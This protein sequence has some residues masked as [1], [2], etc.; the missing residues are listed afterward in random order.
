MKNLH[1]LILC[2][3]LVLYA[4]KEEPNKRKNLV[5]YPETV[6]KPVIETYF[7]TKVIDNYRWLEDDRSPETEEWVTTE[8]K[9]TFNYLS[10]IPYRKQLKN[11]LSELWNYEKIGAPFIE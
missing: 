4:C 1:I 10:N 3:A 11:R 7:D 5:N 8:N 2:F 6:K 9:V